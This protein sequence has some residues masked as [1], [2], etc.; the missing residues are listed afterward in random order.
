[1]IS[2]NL[3]NKAKENMLVTE[4][5]DRGLACIQVNGE[6][7]YLNT[8]QVKTVSQFLELLLQNKQTDKNGAYKLL[9]DNVC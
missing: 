1:M 5:K 9:K 4:A 3:Y 8:A 6:V 2:L 7:F